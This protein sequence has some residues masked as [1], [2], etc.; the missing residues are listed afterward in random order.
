M[1]FIPR[2]ILCIL[3]CSRADIIGTKKLTAHII[4][5][6][7]PRVFVILQYQ[8]D[9]PIRIV[10]GKTIETAEQF[11]LRCIFK[12]QIVFII[13]CKITIREAK[14]DLHEG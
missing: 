6:S 10:G 2:K 1:L 3:M 12:Q 5:G 14:S 4:V 13:E 11:L 8:L 9:Y 7:Y